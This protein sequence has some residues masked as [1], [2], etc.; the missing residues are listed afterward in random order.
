VTKGDPRSDLPQHV[1]AHRTRTFDLNKL[2][3]SIA[4]SALCEECIIDRVP[5]LSR[6]G[7]RTMIKDLKAPHFELFRGEC[8]ACLQQAD[9]IRAV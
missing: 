3:L 2:L 7:A 8:A 4:P 5:A 1:Q 9:L 6:P